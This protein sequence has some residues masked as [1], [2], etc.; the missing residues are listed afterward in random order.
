MSTST[1]DRPIARI[2]TENPIDLETAAKV[3][4]R[5]DLFRSVSIRTVF[6]WLI[7]G[8]KGVKLEGVR[9][10]GKWFTSVEAIGRFVE[11]VKAKEG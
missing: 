2:R 3:F 8:K 6:R 11:A 7:G 10:A 9:I 4:P 1:R 5:G